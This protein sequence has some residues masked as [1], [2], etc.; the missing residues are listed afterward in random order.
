MK[1]GLVK[2]LAEILK[3]RS[4]KERGE[5]GA[6]AP[7]SE[8]RVTKRLR[9]PGDETSYRVVKRVSS[10]EEIPEGRKS[11]TK[12]KVELEDDR[13]SSTGS[14]SAREMEMRSGS[15]DGKAAQERG[16]QLNSEKQE[17]LVERMEKPVAAKPAV[18]KSVEK[19]SPA[20]P[21][22][23]KRFEKPMHASV[24]K[25]LVPPNYVGE[26]RVVEDK[27]TL[28]VDKVSVSNHQKPI[29]EK[30][31]LAVEKRLPQKPVFEKHVPDGHVAVKDLP[32]K[33]QKPVFEKPKVV[34]HVAEKSTPAKVVV[35][36]KVVERN[37]VAVE[38][39]VEKS[40]RV[41]ESDSAKLRDDDGA[42]FLPRKQWKGQLNLLDAW[43][44]QKCQKIVPSVEKTCDKCGAFKLRSEVV[45]YLFLASHSNEKKM[46]F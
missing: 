1:K 40:N 42:A 34:E 45:V 3:E 36:E 7:G 2:S 33:S 17:R 18:G 13:R 35:V 5:R 14:M 11:A 20:K 22:V 28:V 46:L 39:P 32:A 38:Q 6:S 26:K 43:T 10:V 41:V 44:C 15:R 12:Q 21:V 8:D 27:Q 24:E 9:E 29:L 16:M 37:P 25:K 4:E 30:Q 31:P 23:E 19:P